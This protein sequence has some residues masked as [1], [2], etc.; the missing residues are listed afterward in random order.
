MENG[1]KFDH[2]YALLIAV[3][4]NKTPRWSLPAVAN[5]VQRLYQVLLHPQ[6]CAYPP[7]QVRV[8][9]GPAAGREGI[10]DGLDWL[11]RRAAE[12]PLA[13]ALIY[14]SGHGWRAL[15][16]GGYYLIPYDVQERRLR[17]TALRAEDFAAEVRRLKAPR[18]LVLLDCC[19][20]GGMGVKAAGEETFAPSAFPAADLMAGEPEAFSPQAK[21]LESLAQGRGRAVISSSQ[22]D[23]NSYLR[24]D[25]Q[26]SIFTYHLIE[27]LTGHARPQEAA[28]Q[29]LTSDLVSYVYRRVPES[30]LADHGKL[31]QPDCQMSGVFPVALLLGGKGLSQGGRPPDPLEAL[32]PVPRPGQVNTGGGPFF[33]GPFQGTYVA[34]YWI[35]D[36]HVEINAPTTGTLINTGNGNSIQW[37][38]SEA[39]TLEAFL[40]LLRDLSA[41]LPQAGL[42]PQEQAEV[43][44]DL[45]RVAE[46]ARAPEPNRQIILKR[47]RSAV[48]FMADA[49]TV[50]AAAPHLIEQGRRLLEWAA[51]LF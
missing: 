19:H 38:P 11:R 33:G 24:A 35:Q 21:G 48:D 34:G 22:G 4:E 1:M 39:P 28:D 20:A 14:F 2:G 18:L 3:N 43:E 27:A 9:Q 10:L 6:R 31:Q 29:V 26:M 30:A 47:L 5:D 45:A 25:G 7:Q 37:L 16:D 50:V 44:E 41:A 40:S 46:Q 36:H 23:Q 51:R 13:T 12:D 32:P 17:Y 42:N 8:L 15:D 49:A